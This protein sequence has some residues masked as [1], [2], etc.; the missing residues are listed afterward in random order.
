MP[1]F[2]L[3]LVL[4]RADLVDRREGRVLQVT[5]GSTADDWNIDQRGLCS[6]SEDEGEDE[7]DV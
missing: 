4:G 5:R 2:G 7:G 6:H 1:A 3:L